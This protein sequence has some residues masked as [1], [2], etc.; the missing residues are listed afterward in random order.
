MVKIILFLSLILNIFTVNSYA[1]SAKSAVL[2]DIQSG[3]VLYEHNAYEKLPMASTTKIMTGLLACESGKLKESVKASAFASGTEGS[4]LWLKI[5][6]EQTL[7]NLTYGL[8]LKSGNDAAVAIAEHLGGCTDA[9]ALL[10]NK[11]AREIGAHNTNFENPHGLDSSGHYTTA[12]DLA[13]ISREAMKNKKFREIVSTKTYSIPMEGEK[14][15]RALKNHNKM[16][17][18]YDGCNG[19]KTGFTKKCG[20][21]LVTSAKRDGKE[22]VC[23]T[24]NAPSDWNDHTELLDFGFNNYEKKTLYKKGE[25]VCDYTYDKKNGKK[26]SLVCK[27]GFSTLLCKDEKLDTKIEYHKI[28]APSKKGTVAATLHIFC[29]GVEISSVP[30]VTNKAIKKVT[31]FEKVNTKMRR[32]FTSHFC[33]V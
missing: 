25:K 4:S 22:L 21:C 1:I 9:F 27:E 26:V 17:W 3:R 18:R 13:I 16:L 33:T 20:R 32:V 12:Y 30:L 29:N 23:V 6:E 19:V 8:M 11:K 31:F 10:M 2:I 7:E 28:K 15:D 14:W 24:L 5:G